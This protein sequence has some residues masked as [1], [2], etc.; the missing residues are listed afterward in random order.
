MSGHGTGSLVTCMTNAAYVL[1]SPPASQCFLRGDKSVQCSCESYGLGHLVCE[2]CVSPS[3]K[4]VSQTVSHQT[5]VSDVPNQTIRPTLKRTP[6]TTDT[7]PSRNCRLPTCTPPKHQFSLVGLM[8]TAN[9]TTRH[10]E[11]SQVLVLDMRGLTGPGVRFSPVK[12]H[13]TG[14]LLTELAMPRPS[15]CPRFF[16]M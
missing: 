2:P 4:L 7:L 3:S 14:M 5:S 8:Q 15:S 6:C 13:D 1:T 11:D 10:A 12:Q 9:D 16:N